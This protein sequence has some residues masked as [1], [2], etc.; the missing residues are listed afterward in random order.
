LNDAAPIGKPAFLIE[1]ERT[2]SSPDCTQKVD[3][4]T[5]FNTLSEREREIVRLVCE[6]KSN[7]EIA[8]HTCR[9]IGSVK[10]MLHVVFKKLRVHS[11]ANIIAQFN[12]GKWFL[13]AFSSLFASAAGRDFPAST[14]VAPADILRFSVDLFLCTSEPL[15]NMMAA[16]ELITQYTSSAPLNS[17]R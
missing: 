9:A 17:C 1:F 8:S 12:S 2:E 15:S 10:N 6:G 13:L 16:A 11:R 7:Q 3:T 5:V 14:A 4:R